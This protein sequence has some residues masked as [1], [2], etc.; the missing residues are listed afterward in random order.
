M[1]FFGGKTKEKGKGFEVVR[2]SRMPPGMEMEEKTPAGA[3][4]PLIDEPES[5]KRRLQLEDEGDAVGGG[6]RHLPGET[7]STTRGDYVSVDGEGFQLPEIDAGESIHMPSRWASR[8]ST[9]PSR[10]PSTRDAGR[11]ADRNIPPVPDFPPQL[12]FELE[13]VPDVPRKSSRR[14]SVF[15]NSNQGSAEHVPWIDT[16]STSAGGSRRGSGPSQ[17]AGSAR[18]SFPAQRIPFGN[19][20]TTPATSRH[21]RTFS[22][23]SEVS[24]VSAVSR[25]SEV[26]AL[27]AENE[28]QPPAWRDERPSSLGYVQQHRASDGIRHASGSVQ[29]GQQSL[30][31]SSAELVEPERRWN[32]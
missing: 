24:N 3:E 22:G 20:L 12:E 2:S 7:G 30:T 11:E 10:G 32:V 5:S 9:K 8:A 26:S 25:T 14:V 27:T 13:T 6:T 29:G 31:G 1:G 4:E 17:Q 15:T 19:T 28:N 21:V 18:G 16:T 23:G